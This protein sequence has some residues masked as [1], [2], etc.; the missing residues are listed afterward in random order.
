MDWFKFGKGVR[1]RNISSSCLFNLYSEN[2]MWNARLDESQ[3]GI[4]IVKRNVNNL[5][6]ADDTTLESEELKNRLMRLKE[7]F[8]IQKT[9]IIA[10]C[11][12]TSAQ[13]FSGSKI[14]E[15]GDCSHDDKPKQHVKKQRHHFA[16]KGLYSQSYGLPSTHVWGW[17]LNHKEG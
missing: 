5:R 9:K 17:Q 4:K 13:I 6:Y 16:D 3:A 11:P 10:S 7:E 15:D 8:N 1:Q 12:I 2:I 14:A